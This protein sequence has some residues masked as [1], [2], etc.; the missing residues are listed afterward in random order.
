MS[1][2]HV[3]S[4]IL[5][6]FVL[7][8]EK[9]TCRHN[10]IIQFDQCSTSF[11]FF[12]FHVRVGGTVP[13]AHAFADTHV[14][15]LGEIAFCAITSSE[16][17][18]GFGARLMNYTKSPLGAFS[19][20]G[21]VSLQGGLKDHHQDKGSRRKLDHFPHRMPWPHAWGGDCLGHEGT[22]DPRTMAHATPVLS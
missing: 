8:E 13:L 10:E 1:W 5:W 20:Q 7:Y 2:S 4:A 11:P 15:G 6:G 22:L 3:V 16:Q 17:V 19:L 14:Q 12:Y 21:A 9:G 18:K